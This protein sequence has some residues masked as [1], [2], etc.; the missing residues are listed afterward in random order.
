MPEKIIIR[1]VKEIEQRI[2]EIVNVIDELI[3][4]PPNLLPFLRQ[5]D[6]KDLLWKLRFEKSLLEWV[7]GG[8]DYLKK[9]I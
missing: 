2:F 3:N 6:E 7:L 1:E 4:R 5:Q 8:E 9:E